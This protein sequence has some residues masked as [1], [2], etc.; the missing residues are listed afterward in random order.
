M[1]NCD[2][3]LFIVRTPFQ[4]WFCERLI[5]RLGI[6]CYDFLYITHNNSQEDIFYYNNLSPGARNSSYVFV[7]PA[8]FDVFTNLKLFYRVK[9]WFSKDRYDRV[10]MASINS[11]IINSLACSF[12]DAELFSFDDGTANLVEDGPY[13]TSDSSFRSRFYSTIFGAR[14]VE[15]VRKKISRHYTIYRGFNNIVEEARLSYFDGWVLNRRGKGDYSHSAKSKRYFI[16]APFHEVMSKAEID[17]M[18]RLLGALRIDGYIR[19]P[20]EIQPLPIDAPIIDKGGRIAEDVII[21]C[22]SG[23]RVELYGYLSTVMINLKDYADKKVVFVPEG[24]ASSRLSELALDSGCE[25]VY[26]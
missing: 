3:A 20:R 13:Y 7:K 25:I 26:V 19:H 10:Y 15:Q 23:C 6:S 4:A 18:L 21:D 11:Y 5:E 24:N 17:S 16:G 9:G 2:K 12:H 8:S 22:S 14:P 1:R